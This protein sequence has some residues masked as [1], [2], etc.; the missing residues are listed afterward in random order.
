[1]KTTCLSSLRRCNVKELYLK[2]NRIHRFNVV[3][4]L[5][6]NQ[7]SNCNES[8][9]EIEVECEEMFLRSGLDV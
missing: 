1:M 2:A 8:L 7:T 9:E 6:L 4:R 5:L 3:I